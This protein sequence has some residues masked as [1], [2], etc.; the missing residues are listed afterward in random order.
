MNLSSFNILHRQT[1]A[2]ERPSQVK[3]N[4]SSIEHRRV[5]G[6]R[7]GTG[8]C[9]GMGMGIG[10]GIVL[11]VHLKSVCARTWLSSPWPTCERD[12]CAGRG[13][14]ATLRR[15]PPGREGA[16]GWGAAVAEAAWRG[17]TP[18]C[19]SRF[20][21]RFRFPSKPEPGPCLCPCPCPRLRCRPALDWTPA[22]PATTTPTPRSKQS[23]QRPCPS[24]D[25]SH[26]FSERPTPT[27]RRL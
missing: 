27:D 25:G 22:A 10:I 12:L 15:G 6:S 2:R 20:R 14:G 11:R 23:F 24:T 19:P 16:P 5:T 13:M 3:V 9:M 7:L 8:I 18:P 17:R 4:T 1:S 21:F 26:R